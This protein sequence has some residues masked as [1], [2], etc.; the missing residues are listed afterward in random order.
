MASAATPIVIE[1]HISEVLEVAHSILRRHQDHDL[2]QKTFVMQEYLDLQRKRPGLDCREPLHT[3]LADLTAAVH[4]HLNAE[5]EA[6]VTM[7][8]SLY[9]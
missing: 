5:V 7:F 4:R 2:A 6:V 3:A 1:S 8:T 9:R